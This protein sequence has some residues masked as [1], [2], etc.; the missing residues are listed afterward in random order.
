MAMNRLFST[1][2][3]QRGFTLIELMVT[4]S[5]AAI[6]LVVVVPSFRT[7]TLS[8]RVKTG[9]FDLYST[10]MLARSEA[11]KRRATVTVAAKSGSWNNGWTISDGTTTFRDQDSPKGLS[12]TS[13]A[14]ALTYQIDGRL[15]SGSASYVE[16]AATGSTAAGRRCMT[17][18]PAGVP[19]SRVLTGSATCP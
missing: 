13:D 4:I 16:L 15:V 19:R 7:F 2:L 17:I 6:L 18:D 3:G 12:L 9:S 10:L 5:V 1:A 11:V 8:Q 14:T